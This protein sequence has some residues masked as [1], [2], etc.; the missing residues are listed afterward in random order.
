MHTK[1]KR[2]QFCNSRSLS[3]NGLRVVVSNTSGD[4]QQFTCAVIERVLEPNCSLSRV[5]HTRATY[6]VVEAAKLPA[7]ALDGSFF[8]V[9]QCPASRFHPVGKL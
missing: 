2:V 9:L 7:A 6:S 4:P 3:D 8:K 5:K 1:Q